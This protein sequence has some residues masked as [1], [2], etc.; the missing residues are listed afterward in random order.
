M[1]SGDLFLPA[2][3]PKKRTIEIVD[4]IENFIIITTQQVPAVR[5]SEQRSHNIE[6]S[7][8]AFAGQDGSMIR[9]WR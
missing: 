8:K 2:T 6:H 4:G 5:T 1:Q 3:G 7:L 9:N